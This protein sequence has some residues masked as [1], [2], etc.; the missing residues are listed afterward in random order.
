MSFGYDDFYENDFAF[1][2]T[3]NFQPLPKYVR[4]GWTHIQLDEAKEAIVD[5]IEFTRQHHL[6]LL[7]QMKANLIGSSLFFSFHI[8]NTDEPEPCKGVFSNGSD[9]L[10][11]LSTELFPLLSSG[12]P[13]IAIYAR[14][15]SNSSVKFYEQF[16]VPF[17]SMQRIIVDAN[18]VEIETNHEVEDSQF[19]SVSL[20]PLIRSSNGF[21]F[22]EQ[23][24]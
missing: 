13:K 8:D 16:L 19:C 22:L 4:I 1:L 11:Y 6:P 5:G 21:I 24:T 20:F 3:T 10:T 18:S 23:T 7:R 17:L 12:I 15:L 14:C 9:P 2:T